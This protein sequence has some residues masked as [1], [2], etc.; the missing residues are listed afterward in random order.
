LKR[1]FR[2]KKRPK[3]TAR[4]HN[5]DGRDSSDLP[6]NLNGALAKIDENLAE[7]DLSSSVIE[8]VLH[9]P[10]GTLQRKKYRNEK[11][12]DVKYSSLRYAWKV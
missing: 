10:D 4:D 12:P 5:P 1:I 11:F 6:E 2:L 9:R 3:V 7:I 8:L